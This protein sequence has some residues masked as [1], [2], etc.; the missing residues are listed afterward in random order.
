MAVHPSPHDPSSRYA[1]ALHRLLSLADLERMVGASTA[2]YKLDLA[3]MRELAQRLGAPQLTAPVAHVAGTKGKGSVA[4]TVA[5]IL[6]ASGRRVGLFTSPHLHTFRERLRLDGTL[7]TEL[8]FASALERVWP[9]VEAMKAESQEGSPTTFETLTAMAFALFR[10]EAVDV[11][12]LEV[13]LGGRL[14]ATNVAEAAVHVITSISLDHTAILGDTLAK[15]AGEKAGIIKTPAPVVVAP[16]PPEAMEVILARAAAIGAPVTR[17]GTDVTITPLE[18]SLTGQSFIVKTAAGEH[19]L[20]GRLLGEHQ[21]ENAALAVA[22]VEALGLPCPPAAFVDGVASVRWDGRFQVLAPLPGAE[23][24]GPVVVV[25]GAHNPYS[26]GRL[27]ETAQE[28]VAPKHTTIVFG[29]SRDKDLEGM[30]DALSGLATSVVA[31]ASR[32]P[33]AVAP[34][35]AAAAFERAGI[36]ARTAPDLPTALSMAQAECGTGDLV[37]VTGSLFVVAEA[38]ETWFGIAPEIYPELDPEQAYASGGRP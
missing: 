10:D 12:V 38:L 18:H 37:L 34:A 17:V 28:Y 13:G 1:D 20:T 36:P 29:C 9:H 32:H 14:D 21:R 23:R 27:R 8:Q 4:A 5:S 3:R 26:A 25:D 19:R 33:R 7:S 35:E 15:V 30:I 2:Q 16:Q 6:R 31:C 24:S 11:Q 22:A